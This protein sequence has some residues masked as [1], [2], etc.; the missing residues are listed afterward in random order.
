M[1]LAKMIPMLLSVFML[2]GMAGA[3]IKT[4]TIK[5]KDGDVELEG[6]LA[7]DDAIQGERPGVMII[8][9]WMGT[10]EYGERRARELAALGYVA[11][12][13]DIFGPASKP[14][15]TQ[16]AGQLAGKF[17]SDADLYRKRLNLGLEQLRARPES[18]NS[19]L[20]AIG[21]CFGGTGV[22]ELARSGADVKGV[23]SF[24]GGLGTP[25]PAAKGAVKAKVLVLHGAADSYVPADEIAGLKKELDAAG[26]DWQMIYYS[27]AVHSFSKKEAGDDTASGN[28]YDATADRRS[29]KHMQAFFDEIFVK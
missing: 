19:R 25:K 15:N 24:H 3:A 23:V 18:D 2:S 8:H 27:G 22:L 29:W 16:D 12:A 5:Y 6:F 9:D 17:K 4:E 13:A 28:A 26:V 20:A 10:G 21:Y 11:F 14:K 1:R 7:W